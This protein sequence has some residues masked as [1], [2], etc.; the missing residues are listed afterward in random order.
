LIPSKAIT[1]AAVKSCYYI[2]MYTALISD[3][4]NTLVPVTGDGSTID[5]TTLRS[6]SSA[7]HRGIQISVAT[8]RGWSST[9]PVV[10][11]LGLE[12]LCIIEGGGCIIDPQTEKLVWEKLV[13]AKT[14]N[15]VVTIFKQYAKSEELVKSSGRPER[16]GVQTIGD[17]SFENR[18]IYLLGTSEETAQTV[19]DVLAQVSSVAVNI[20]TPSWAGPDLFDVHVTDKHRTKEYALDEWYRLMGIKKAECVAMGDSANDL[21]LFNAVGLKVAVG[22][23]TSEL[24]AQADYIAPDLNDNPLKHVLEK[25]FTSEAKSDDEIRKSIKRYERPLPEFERNPNVQADVEKLIERA[26]QPHPLKPEKRRRFDGYT[27]IQTHSHNTEGTSVK[28]SGKS[29]PKSA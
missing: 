5:D 7:I 15:Q 25:F 27:G 20:T 3:V 29:R 14:S 18:V 11:R 28:R 26:S 23:A 24:K 16:L 13:D 4:D 6:V 17:Y 1:I 2:Y 10:K 9:K 19:K 12:D 22:N 8:G 21:P